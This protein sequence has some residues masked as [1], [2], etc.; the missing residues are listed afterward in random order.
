MINYYQNKVECFSKS[1]VKANNIDKIL[2]ELTEFNIDFQDS[3]YHNT[4]Q[5]SINNYSGFSK[6]EIKR[7]KQNLITYLF[8]F[9][10]FKWYHN[11]PVF[12]D[13][14]FSAKNLKIPA[15]NLLKSNFPNIKCYSC[16]VN[17][18]Y[19]EKANNMLKNY[20]NVTYKLEKSPELSDM[21]DGDYKELMEH[22]KILEG[23]NRHASIHAAGVVIAPGVLTDYVPLYKSTT[24][25]VTS[26][27]DMK[28]L[29][30]LG[31]LKMDF[32]GLR[33]LTVIDKAI[34]LIEQKAQSVDLD[35][36]SFENSKVYE[37]FFKREYYWGFSI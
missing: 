32:L 31:L 34:K 27:Y 2:K 24:D 6:N 12:T 19:Y 8:S 7:F 25:D 29:E 26:Q 5:K 35:K 36:L 16:E 9:T 20:S 33:N 22:S 4:L 37:L 1:L 10:D 11:Y 21:A 28:G 18:S 30:E 23:M 13:E 14:M 17:K 3:K 15:L